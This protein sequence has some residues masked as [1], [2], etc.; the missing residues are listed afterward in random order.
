MSANAWR[1]LNAV[2]K[3]SQFSMDLFDQWRAEQ[4]EAIADRGSD[5]DPAVEEAHNNFMLR[6]NLNAYICY[7][8]LD[9]YTACLEKHNLIEHGDDRREINTRNSINEKKCRATHIAYVGCMGSR[10]N[11]ETLLQNAA[12]HSSCASHHVSL[13]ECYNT[14]REVETSTEVP[15]CVPFYRRLIR[16]GLNHLWNDYWRALT[17]FGEAED[18][19]LY[20]LSRDENK[21]QEFLRAITSSVEEQRNYLRTRREQEKGYFLSNPSDQ[22]KGDTKG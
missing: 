14:N 13:M 19:H 3:H 17:N 18:Y 15:Q 20:E 21:K 7:K 5:P 9:E 11:H 6:Q 1:P 2:S 22:V 12:L 16:C 10:L 4:R 8:Q